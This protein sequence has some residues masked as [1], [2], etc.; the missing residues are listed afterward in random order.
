MKALFRLN[1]QLVTHTRRNLWVILVVVLVAAGFVPAAQAQG[2]GDFTHSALM[3]KDTIKAAY[4]QVNRYVTPEQP[5]VRQTGQVLDQAWSAAN[6]MYLG[7]A[8]DD[9]FNVRDGMTRLGAALV[10]GDRSGYP[11]LVELA[12]PNRAAGRRLQ[13]VSQWLIAQDQPVQ[14]RVADSASALAQFVPLA[15]LCLP[16][17]LV[18]VMADGWL[19]TARHASI[20]AAVPVGLPV[21]AAVA[22]AVRSGLA[23]LAIAGAMGLVIGGGALVGG[24]GALRYPFTLSLGAR[25]TAVPMWVNPVVLLTQ[26]LL[27][28]SF[29]GSL[30]LLLNS[31]C[32]NVWLG[33]VLGWG[34]VSVPL[35][36]PAIAHWAWLPLAGLTPQAIMTGAV[37]N[38]GGN[39]ALGLIG[40]DGIMLLWSAGLLGW[41]A[42]RTQRLAR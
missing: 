23:V 40:A 1:W 12:L 14:R 20:Q 5:Q 24:L 39:W 25:L 16:F 6:V 18:V 33:L 10:A 42:W 17:L 29:V 4:Q 31:W 8:M 28:S 19:T 22:L 7:G 35:V 41:F 32:H 27:V 9:A 38:D 21:Q 37:Q 2:L 13:L 11:G 3:T 34:V 30:M 36:F 15:M 26:T